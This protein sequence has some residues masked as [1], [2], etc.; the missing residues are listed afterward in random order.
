MNKDLNSKFIILPILLLSLAFG[1]LPEM[2]E[3][4]VVAKT[5]T[6]SP[7]PVPAQ[8]VD[9]KMAYL[10]N[11]LEDESLSDEDKQRASDLLSTYKKF[12]AYLQ[13][14]SAETDHGMM[15]G[16]LYES[17]S[18]LDEAYFSRK[19]LEGPQYSETLTLF[20][21]KRREILD[22]YLSGDYEGVINECVELEAEFGPDSLLPEIALIFAVSLAKKG[23]LKDAINISESISPEF[24]GRPDL[25]HLRANMIAWQLDVGDREK[26]LQIYEKLIDDVDE[27]EA[28]LSS[29]RQMLT[30]EGRAS[31]PKG[32]P[33]EEDATQQSYLLEEA[34][35]ERLLKNVDER[36][37]R[38]EFEEAKLLLIKRK[39]RLQEGAPELEKI[40]QALSKVDR[41]EE[42]YEEEKNAKLAHEKETF[43]LARRLIEQENYEEAI[44]K[45][46]ALGSVQEPTLQTR[47]L[48]DLATEGLINRERNKAAKYFLMARK[49]TDPEKKE[50]LL[51]ASLDILKVLAENY[52]SSNLIGKVN[53]NIKAVRIELGKLGK[54]PEY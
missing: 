39:I 54:Y 27:K 38:H 49:T 4:V 41:A 1:C 5:E 26:A 45:L 12:K 8:Q 33:T 34:S 35:L 15:I 48:K 50:Q 51:L 6:V 17:L 23:M 53:D 29:S 37:S 52:P 13:V 25:I 43:E 31:Y 24:E 32:A 14:Q 36:I 11:I 30:V 9:E 28:L 21:F 47:A 20:S 7:P 19:G 44:S 3:W 40:D 16:M 2:K 10:E 42:E 22:K 46:E 18:R